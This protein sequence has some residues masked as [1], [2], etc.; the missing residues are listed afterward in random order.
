MI[1]L[2]VA[3]LNIKFLWLWGRVSVYKLVCKLHIY[4]IHISL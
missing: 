3:L 1:K 2:Y 4:C